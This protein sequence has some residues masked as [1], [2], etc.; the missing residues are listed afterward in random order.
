VGMDL[1][2]AGGYFRWTNSEWGDVLALGEAFGWV[3]MGFGPPCG[4]LKADWQ[5]GSYVGNDGQRF[6]ARDARALADALE[7][8][9]ASVS[10][11]RSP[12]RTRVARATDYLE[13]KLMNKK[14]PRR[15][16]VAVR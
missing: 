13:A 3:P 5:G 12:V 8:A 2:G 14:V 4:V 15:G 9:V 1:N 11:G 16:R 6:Y 7:R 10:E